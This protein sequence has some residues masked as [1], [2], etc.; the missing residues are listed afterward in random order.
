MNKPELWI[1][2]NRKQA[3]DAMHEY[4][5]RN[6]LKVTSEKEVGEDGKETGEFLPPFQVDAGGEGFVQFS[7]VP[8]LTHIN[9]VGKLYHGIFMAPGTIV[10]TEQLFQL[11][12]RVRA[13]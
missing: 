13:G 1:Y 10:P 9:T 6:G 7:E 12:H 5:A 11:Q 2:N 3:L 8:W 4:A